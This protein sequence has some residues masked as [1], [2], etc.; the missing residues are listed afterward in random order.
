MLGFL[1]D[2][3]EVAVKVIDWAERDF[4]LDELQRLVNMDVSKYFMNKYKVCTCMGCKTSENCYIKYTYVRLTSWVGPTSWA[5]SRSWADFKI[6]YHF[7]AY[8]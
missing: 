7:G 3:T 8:F 4:T 5:S 2:G 1:A 6:A